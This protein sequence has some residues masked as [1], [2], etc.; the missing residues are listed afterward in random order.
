MGVHVT[1]GEWYWHLLQTTITSPDLRA[2][3]KVAE[4]LL[5]LANRYISFVYYIYFFKMKKYLHF[6]SFLEPSS[7][8]PFHAKE[9]YVKILHQ[10][11]NEAEKF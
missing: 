10:V 4:C 6:G 8:T 7:S 11:L 1:V 5:H 3:A 9:R 2:N